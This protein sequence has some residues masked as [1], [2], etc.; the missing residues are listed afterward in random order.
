[1]S[2]PT[3]TP[4]DPQSPQDRPKPASSGRAGARDIAATLLAGGKSVRDAATGA[5][6][7]ERTVRRWSNECTAFQKLVRDIRTAAM[8]AALGR[9]TDGMAVRDK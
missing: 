2:D 1:M 8:T 5:G 4:D 6:V 3:P 9:L 7:S